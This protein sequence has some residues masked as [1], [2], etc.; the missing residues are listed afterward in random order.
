LEQIFVQRDAERTVAFI[1]ALLA[2]AFGITGT[3]FLLFP[4]GTVRVVNAIGSA[5]RVFAPAPMSELRFWLGLAVAYMVLVTL[6]AARIAAAPSANQQLMPILA[7]GKFTSSILSLFFFVFSRPTLLYFLNFVVDGAIAIS[8]IGCYAW[9]GLATSEHRQPLEPRTRT[10]RLLEVA[11]DALLPGSAGP[12]TPAEKRLDRIV[13]E[14]FRDVHPAGSIGLAAMLHLLEYGPYLLGPRRLLFSRLDG[15]QR[16]EYLTRCERSRL[17]LFRAPVQA[18]KLVTMLHGYEMEERCREIGYDSE[19]VRAK[20][21]AGPNRGAHGAR[22]GGAGK[23]DRWRCAFG[24]SN[25][26]DR[27]Q[28]RLPSVGT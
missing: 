15:G 10:A 28:L 5:L 14:Y 21:L 27:H 25:P 9:L 23:R 2:W 3:V 22:R 1:H 13:W 24:L 17:A 26:R 4:D 8:V 19:Y 7:A 12:G 18:L 20:L 11:V 6:L 16:E